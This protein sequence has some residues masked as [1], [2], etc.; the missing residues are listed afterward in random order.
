MFTIS[1]ATSIEAIQKLEKVLLRNNELI[2]VSINVDEKIG[3]SLLN[4]SS[5][6]FIFTRPFLV[7]FLSEAE[8]RA[9]IYWRA[10]K[11]GK[12]FKLTANYENFVIQEITRHLWKQSLGEEL[13]I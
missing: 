1:A 10:Q 11:T 2:A 13:K 12:F 3:E 7:S 6:N 4:L 5:L 9:I 8:N